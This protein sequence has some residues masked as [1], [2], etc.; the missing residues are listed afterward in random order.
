MM[1]TRGNIT[2]KTHGAGDPQAP[3]PM[4]H[5]QYARG[6]LIRGGSIQISPQL[7]MPM[8][9]M[10]DQKTWVYPVIFSAR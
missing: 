9:D 3:P 4:A 7:P 1:F 8:A 10:T 6:A 5:A 2:A